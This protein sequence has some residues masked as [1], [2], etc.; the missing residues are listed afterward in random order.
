[1]NSQWEHYQN[2]NWAKVVRDGDEA[3]MRSRPAIWSHAPNAT[4]YAC[5]IRSVPRAAITRASKLSKSSP[6]KTTNRR[7]GMYPHPYP[8]QRPCNA[9]KCTALVLPATLAQGWSQ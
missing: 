6:T 1:M 5:P 2:T 4:S 7:C 3:T 9:V 8:E